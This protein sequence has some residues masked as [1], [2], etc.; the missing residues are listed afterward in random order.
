MGIQ[1]I[2]LRWRGGMGF[3]PQGCHKMDQGKEGWD[4][5]G[6]LGCFWRA[7]VCSDEACDHEGGR[8][9]E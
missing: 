1:Q 6:A 8:G 9:W 4:K 7:Q 5:V 2:S 3:T